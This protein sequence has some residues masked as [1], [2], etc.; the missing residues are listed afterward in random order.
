MTVSNGLWYEDE[1]TSPAQLAAELERAR[2]ERDSMTPEQRAEMAAFL[3]DGLT[4]KPKPAAPPPAPAAAPAAPAAPEP[5]TSESERILEGFKSGKYI[6]NDRDIAKE[7][8][9]ARLAEYGV[10][11]SHWQPRSEG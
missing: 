4:S 11:P 7:F 8:F 1:E 5:E 9:A 3:L 10:R 6:P 2:A